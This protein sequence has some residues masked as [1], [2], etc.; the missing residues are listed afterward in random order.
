MEEA[1]LAYNVSAIRKALGDG[2]ETERYIETVP[3]RGIPVRRPVTQRATGAHAH[4]H[5]ADGASGK[6]PC[7]PPTG[8]TGRTHLWLAWTVAAIASSA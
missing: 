1:I 5:D 2:S 6:T 8:P 3:R 7:E 4:R